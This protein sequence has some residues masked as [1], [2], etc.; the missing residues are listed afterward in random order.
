MLT[1]PLKEDGWLNYFQE[2]FSIKMEKTQSR[3][4]DEPLRTAINIGRKEVGRPAKSMKN[5]KPPG[6]GGILNEL[7]KHGGT[8]LIIGIKLTEKAA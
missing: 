5:I 4:Q 1:T 6:P 2:F 7:I 3:L 8:H